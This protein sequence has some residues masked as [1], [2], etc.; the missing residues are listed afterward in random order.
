[1]AARRV[2]PRGRSIVALVLAAFLVVSG[3]VVWR[4]SRGTAEARRLHDLVTR[5]AE[6]DAERAQLESE[7]QRLLSRERLVPVAQRL[8]LVV[9]ADSQLIY[10]PRP[11]PK[12]R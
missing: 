11:E 9:P 12:E 6:L 8:G 7:I 3:S 4:R 1:M 5:R 2:A 10:L